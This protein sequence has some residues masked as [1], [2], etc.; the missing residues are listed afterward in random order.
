[1]NFIEKLKAKFFA[2]SDTEKYKVV[3]QD[4]HLNLY[5][6]FFEA[7]NPYEKIPD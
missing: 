1:M 2:V 3:K 7:R 4:H 6:D 5:R